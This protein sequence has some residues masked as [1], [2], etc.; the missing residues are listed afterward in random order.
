MNSSTQVISHPS[1]SS[2]FSKSISAKRFEAEKLT[3]F[4]YRVKSQSSASGQKSILLSPG[5]ISGKAQGI[6]TGKAGS[7]NIR[8]GYLDER[9]GS[10]KVTVT[11]AGRTSALKLDRTS[12]S[13]KVEK[14]LFANIP[15]KSGDR[16]QIA[17]TANQKDRAQL[18][19]IDFI[20]TSASAAPLP[21]TSTTPSPIKSSKSISDN[22][23]GNW[24]PRWQ[25]QTQGDWGEKN[26]QVVNT[27]DSKYGNFLR[28]H[29]PAGSASPTVT[30][31]E[32]APQGG[33]QFYATFGMAPQ[34]SAH[35]SYDLRFSNNFDFVQ[36]GKLP[37]LYG[38]TGN[39]GGNIPDGTDGFSTRFMWRRE[40]QGE[41]YA[42]LP[43]SKDHGT[44]LGRGAWSFKPGVWHHLEQEVTLNQPGQPNGRVQVWLDGKAV[45]TQNQL[46]FRSTDSLKIN[47]LLFSSFFGGN[48][49]SWATPKDV[50]ADFA[51]F[52]LVPMG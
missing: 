21:P 42:Y 47:G 27:S 4:G 29:Y 31:G 32:G 6:F 10:A 48:D 35:L 12:G 39:N 7:Y 16:F 44:S 14:D 34:T 8:V 41:V 46:N 13:W 17:G 45:F 51:N 22:F 19:W 20:P 37:G 49:S 40:G 30:R 23:S 33:G 25:V 1:T 36:G 26:L 5:T 28:V 2:Q 9:G 50:Y 24:M 18:D 52:S 38:G 43:S 11:V 3:L 15:L